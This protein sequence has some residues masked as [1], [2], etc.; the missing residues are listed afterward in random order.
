MPA[1][2]LA[3][4]NER[5]E[6]VIRVT[7]H[8]V[9]EGYDYVMISS[10]VYGRYLREPGRYPSE[11]AFYRSIFRR[12]KLAEFAPGRDGRGPIIAIHRIGGAAQAR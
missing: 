12:P 1:E 3:A 4:F 8:Y 2:D 6:G 9:G 11:V 5:I 10:A 7:A